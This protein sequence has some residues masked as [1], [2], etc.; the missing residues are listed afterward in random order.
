LLS[1]KTRKIIEEKYSKSGVEYDYNRLQD[2][3]GRLL[4]DLDIQIFY[5]MLPKSFNALN[6]LELGSGTGRFTIPALK[7]GF[8]LM[9]TDVNEIMLK[10]IRKKVVEMGYVDQCQ[11]QVDNIFDLSFNDQSFDFVFSLHVIPR[12][13]TVEDQRAAITEAVRVLKPGGQFLFNYRNSKSLYGHLYSEYAATSQQ[14]KQILDEVGM[15]IV[16]MKG[17]RFT[18]RKLINIMP[19]FISRWIVALDLKLCNCR[20]GRC[21]DVF[22]MAVKE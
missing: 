8:S 14:I 16:Q 18:T 7:R 22:V 6:V 1:Q 20:P 4:S 21:W 15:R 12:F 19:F 10:E 9:A 2:P 11:I 3:R 13:L 17:K 5:K